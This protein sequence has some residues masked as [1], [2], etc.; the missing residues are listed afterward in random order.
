MLAR[1]PWKIRDFL[2]ASARVEQV[3]TQSEQSSTWLS[4]ESEPA[5]NLTVAA[6]CAVS[7]AKRGRS[8]LEWL[9]GHGCEDLA[10]NWRDHGQG[11]VSNRV[12]K[13]AIEEH[14]AGMCRSIT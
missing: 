14:L 12:D 6:D 7:D 9:A 10:R 1:P 11:E 4:E 5:D 3:A 2:A 8:A 13:D